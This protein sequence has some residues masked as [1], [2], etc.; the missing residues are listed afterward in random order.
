MYADV[1]ASSAAATLP[2]TGLAL[3]RTFSL[4]LTVVFLGFALVLLAQRRIA[5]RSVDD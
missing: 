5:A 2:L 4:A 1:R 3:G